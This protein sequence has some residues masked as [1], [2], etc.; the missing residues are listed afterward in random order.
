MGH[1]HRSLVLR[2]SPIRLGG[3][4]K[5]ALCE[6]ADSRGQVLVIGED[7]ETWKERTEGRQMRPAFGI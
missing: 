1:Y 7:T 3:G 6:T 4:L 2:P 5:P